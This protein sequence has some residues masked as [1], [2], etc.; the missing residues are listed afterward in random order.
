MLDRSDDDAAARMRRQSALVHER[1]GSAVGVRDMTAGTCMTCGGTMRW[2]QDLK[3]FKCT[4]CATVNDLVPRV[5]TENDT[6]CAL[7]VA[8]MHHESSVAANICI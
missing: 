6:G 1:R 3:V 7:F 4:L 8:E 2:P 5:A